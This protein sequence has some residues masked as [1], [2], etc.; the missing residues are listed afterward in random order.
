M[1]AGIKVKLRVAARNLGGIFS[2]PVNII[3]AL[4]FAGI[5]LSIIVWWVNIDLVLY[6]VFDAPI[7]F[8]AKVQFMAYVY[9]SLFTSFSGPLAVSVLVLSVLFGANTLLLIRAIQRR[10][11]NAKAMQASGTA[12]VLGLLSGGCAACGTSLV[13][14]L[15]ASVGATSAAA[16]HQAG[17]AFNIL[18][19]V[20]L[21]YSIYRLALMLPVRQ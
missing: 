16:A 13:A 17:L 14:P 11:A 9:Q 15:L 5:M 21:L 20:L 10:S 3:L 6:V 7:S 12:A 19:S 2:S 4:I 1:K 8:G 18:G